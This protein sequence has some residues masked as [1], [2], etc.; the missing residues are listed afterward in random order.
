MHQLTSA[1]LREA[2]PGSVEEARERLREGRG[3]G[4]LQTNNVTSDE[5]NLLVYTSIV[6]SLPL[7]IYACK[8]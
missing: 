7:W 3:G 4:R 5:G 6:L 8:A 1:A 2:Q